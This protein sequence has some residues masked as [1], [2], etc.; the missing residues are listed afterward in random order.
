VSGGS[1]NMDMTLDVSG[2][3]PQLNLTLLGNNVNLGDLMK[4]LHNSDAISGGPSTVDIRVRGA[5]NSVRAIMASLNGTTSV[6]MV[7]GV[8]NNRRIAFLSGDFLKLLTGGGSTTE[9]YCAVSRFTIV[10][11]VANSDALIF[12]ASNLSARGSGAIN[13]GTE[14]LNLLL[15]PETKQPALASLAVPIRVGG[16]LAHPSA[17]PDVAQGVLEAP[18][19][20]L[21][22]VGNAGS[23]VLGTI[24]GGKVGGG[25]VS[26]SSGGCGPMA[27]APPPA[28][29][30]GK[31]APAPTQP[32]STTPVDKVKSLFR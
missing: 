31:K 10:N 12:D 24:T 19:N 29:D 22:S 7:K 28:A 14:G 20:V 4:M 8:L 30:T 5:G 16:T 21:G 15:R 32:K 26:G 25:P 2:A 9:I 18:K 6:S 13:L 1:V 17:A 27:A 23:T 3:T 11:G